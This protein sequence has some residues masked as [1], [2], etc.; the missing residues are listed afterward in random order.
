M[1]SFKPRQ[2]TTTLLA[3]MMLVGTMCCSSGLSFGADFGRG[4]E[5]L[6]EKR[7][8]PLLG[9]FVARFR[10]DPVSYFNLTDEEK[11]LRQQARHLVAPPHARDWLHAV[12]E[13]V[14]RYR[15]TATMDLHLSTNAY[16]AYLR[17]DRFRS[18][19]G[20]YRRLS[21]DIATDAALVPAFFALAGRVIATDVM[22]IEAADLYGPGAPG[23]FS[24]QSPIVRPL[25]SVQTAAQARV[26]EN[27]E[28]IDWADRAVAFR[29]ES[30]RSA[31]E[32]ISIEE[33][34]ARAGYA[35]GELQRLELIFRKAQIDY[36]QQN[37]DIEPVRRS[38]YMTGQGS[39]DQ[40]SDPYYAPVPQK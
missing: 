22:R 11:L 29:I 40:A 19:A 30:Y 13:R 26:F 15:V 21:A 20:R 24:L 32:R 7:V 38:R 23:R 36:L 5:S 33:P 3:Y 34:D 12:V 4:E 2:K 25:T 27:R 31:I 16:Y 9:G 18:T 10:G 37:D 17:S 8:L 1:K 14:Q 6:I 39:S 35:D 28:L